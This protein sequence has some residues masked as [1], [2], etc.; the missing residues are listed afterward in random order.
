MFENFQASGSTL[1]WSRFFKNWVNV[2]WRRLCLRVRWEGNEAH[3]WFFSFPDR[4][5]DAVLPTNRNKK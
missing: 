1:G 4:R 5:S 3:F 2:G